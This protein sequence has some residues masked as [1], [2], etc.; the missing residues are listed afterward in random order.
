MTCASLIVANDYL[1]ALQVLYFYLYIQHYQL[2]SQHVYSIPTKHI[3]LILGITNNKSYDYKLPDKKKARS[4]QDML[5]TAMTALSTL[6]TRSFRSRS[7]NT[8]RNDHACLKKKT[9]NY[10]Y[11]LLLLICIFFLLTCIP[12]TPMH[13]YEIWGPAASGNG[14]SVNGGVILFVHKTKIYTLLLF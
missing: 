7:P 13:L 1:F 2:N 14:V 5:V 10:R 8:R 3:H 12:V 6:G 4:A 9:N 11:T